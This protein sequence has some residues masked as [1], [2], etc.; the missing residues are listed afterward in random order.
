M[1]AAHAEK[2]VAD[3]EIIV[4]PESAMLQEL[5]SYW[6]KK[7]G[8]VLPRAARTSIQLRFRATSHISI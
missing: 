4:E 6:D 8:A 5:V 2:P 7:R 3:M 1:T